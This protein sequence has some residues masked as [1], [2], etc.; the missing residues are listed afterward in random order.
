MLAVILIVMLAVMLM[1]M[2]PTMMLVLPRGGTG[3]RRRKEDSH[4]GQHHN[5]ERRNAHS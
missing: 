4:D 3:T 5:S 1:T 2:M